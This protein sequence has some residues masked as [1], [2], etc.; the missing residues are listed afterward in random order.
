MYFTIKDDQSRIS[1]VMFKHSNRT[2]QFKPEEG[3]Q[4]VVEGS[5]SIY[6]TY[7]EY[8]V[9]VN[10]MQPDGIGSLYMAYEQLKEKLQAEGLFDDKHKQPI[11][12]YPEHI[13]SEERRVGKECKS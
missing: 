5:V 12:A 8:Q 9:Y 10:T 6:D 3:M 1:A 2:L 11:P 13:R 7:G 4:I